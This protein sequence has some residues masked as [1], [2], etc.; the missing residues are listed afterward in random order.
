MIRLLRLEIFKM[1]RR[2]MWLVPL[3]LLTVILFW[4]MASTMQYRSSDTAIS[5]EYLMY[6]HGMI[7]TLLMTMGIA[8]IASRLCDIEL[9]GETLRM[10]V[11]VASAKSVYACKFIYGSIIL[12]LTVVAELASMIF[13]G[14]SQ[15]AQGSVP[16]VHIIGMYFGTLMIAV[17]TLALQQA[18][19]FLVQNQMVSLI[20]GI[21]GSF[22]G[23]LSLLF[24]P[25]IQRLAFW[26]YYADFSAVLM[27]YDTETRVMYF[28]LNPFPW[29]RLIVILGLSLVFY[30]VGQKKF[31]GKEW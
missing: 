26:S 10:L 14:V 9:K 8:V 4:T 1:R 18:L 19:S 16:L 22:L 13:V 21:C 11:P 7:N 6:L 25:A 12:F 24:P 20:T 28:E 27:I 3:L 17:C 30:F 2:K 29:S 15:G 31:A 23:F 5:W